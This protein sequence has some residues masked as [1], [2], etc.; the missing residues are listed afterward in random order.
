MWMAPVQRQTPIEPFMTSIL[1]NARQMISIQSC[2]FT[3]T[4]EIPLVLVCSVC[5]S[6]P[7][8]MG[9]FYMFQPEDQTVHD[10]K[11]GLR[12]KADCCHL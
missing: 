10:I 5:L 7:R 12:T 11:W 9:P 8:G 3:R 4:V 2:E 6:G 1:R